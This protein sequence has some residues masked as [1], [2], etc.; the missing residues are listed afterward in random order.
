MRQW[1]S[2]A[3]IAG[4]PGM[5]TT[6]RGVNYWIKNAPDLQSRPRQGKGGG[7]E[8]HISSLPPET[9]AALRG[10]AAPDPVPAIT[11]PVTE[12][13]AR[14]DEQLKMPLG[15]PEG[16]DPLALI[17]ADW[18]SYLGEVGHKQKA[19]ALYPDLFNG[20]QRPVSGL[21]VWADGRPRQMTV[22]WLRLMDNQG[23]RLGKA[24]APQSGGN[25]FAQIEGDSRL[26]ST[27]LTW[28]KGFLKPNKA[29]LFDLICQQWGPVVS[30]TTLYAYCDWLE[31]QLETRRMLLEYR[32]PDAARSKYRASAGTHSGTVLARTIGIPPP[33]RNPASSSSAPDSACASATSG[34]QLSSQ[35]GVPIGLLFLLQ[36]TR[37]L[38]PWHVWLA[39]LCGHMMRATLTVRRFRGGK[40]REIRVEGATARA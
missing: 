15:I 23:F 21:L 4:L 10:A 19:L 33:F 37:P 7:R 22:G 5:P 40:W 3:E 6:K 8:Y 38:E 14:E 16:L 9:Q 13:L 31:K 28:L 18:Q 35:I 26:K 20:G 17:A 24:S 32:N 29:H 12:T 1:F 30:R 11:H 34:Y 25:R 36:A 39:I 2:P 27:I